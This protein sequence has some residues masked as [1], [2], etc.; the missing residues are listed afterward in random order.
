VTRVEAEEVVP[1][2]HFDERL[3]QTYKRL[4][5][6]KGL[7]ERLAGIRE[8]RYWGPESSFDD[9]AARAGRA[10]MEQAGVAPEQI[11][12]MINASVTR[13]NFEPAVAVGIH[14]SLGLPRHALNFDITNA[15]LGFVNGITVA[16]SMIDAG[17]IDY[18]LI[19]CGEDPSP[20]H[21]TALR[22]LDD[23]EATRDDVMTQFA[24]LTLGSGAA[25]A[26]IGRADRHPEGHRILGSVS[27]AGTE[28]KDL[29]IGGD[30]G[31]GMSTDATGLLKHGLQLVTDAWDQAHEDG[32]DWTDMDSYVTH[33]I[34]TSHTNAIVDAID[35]DPKRIPVTFP[36]WGNVAAAALPMT[37]ALEAERLRPGKR[38]LCMGVGSG[39]NTAL[40]EIAW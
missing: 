19:V 39:L 5:M 33:Q 7:L 20:W 21:E 26:V 15:C 27:R 23:P 12:L 30:A 6:P 32:W 9:G 38:V 37:L 35:V 31:E 17:A 40:M 24:T 3:K 34:S 11:G 14:H 36:Y 29:C 2:S 13:D 10:A 28:H 18:A 8:R 25:A 22:M 1:S 16:S 4:R